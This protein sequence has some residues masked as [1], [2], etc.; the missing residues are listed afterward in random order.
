MCRNTRRAYAVHMRC[1]CVE[2]WVLVVIDVVVAE[3]LTGILFLILREV[4][5]VLLDHM[6]LC[7]L[8]RS[9]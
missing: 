7:H 1:S 8:L 3:V 4:D 6:L 2:L 9:A 5:A